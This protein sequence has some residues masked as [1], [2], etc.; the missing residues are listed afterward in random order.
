MCYGNIF[1]P[2]IGFKILIGSAVGVKGLLSRLY[3]LLVTLEL[4]R[5]RAKGDWEQD[6]KSKFSNK[7]WHAINKLNQNFS[8]NVGNRENH[9]KVIYS[10]MV[11]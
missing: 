7:Q 10:L 3:L 11:I 9:Y 1:Q 4:V 6:L 2:L 5:D 8:V